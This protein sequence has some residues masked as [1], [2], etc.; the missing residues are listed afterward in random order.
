MGLALYTLVEQRTDA[1]PF[2]ERLEDLERTRARWEAEMEAI[3]LKADSTLKSA[4]NAESRSRTMMKHA[5]KLADPLDFES[6]VVEA[7]V[8]EGYAPG[9]EEEELQPLPLD[10]ALTP[11][12]FALR[13][14]FS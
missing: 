14:K 7:A 5:E 13:A 3:L 9:G 4:S 12:E 11:K 2:E 1:G 8:P 6:E 10:V